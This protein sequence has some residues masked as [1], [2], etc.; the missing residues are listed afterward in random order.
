[1]KSHIN[2][3]KQ[4]HSQ[5]EKTIRVS[6]DNHIRDLTINKLKKQKLLLKEEI[7]RLEQSNS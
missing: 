1:M 3:L 2:S 5:L 7:T 4:K 6:N